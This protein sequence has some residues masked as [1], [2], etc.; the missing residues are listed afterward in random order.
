MA[1]SQLFRNVPEQEVLKKRSD[2]VLKRYE[3]ASDAR[4]WSNDKVEKSERIQ[5]ILKKKGISACE[6]PSDA[7]D[8]PTTTIDANENVEGMSKNQLLEQIKKLQREVKVR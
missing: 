5:D 1:F 7:R 4:A 2:A 3:S 8:Q 6:E